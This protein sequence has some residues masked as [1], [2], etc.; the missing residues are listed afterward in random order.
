M[1]D[2]PHIEYLTIRVRG[3]RVVT[4]TI[5]GPPPVQATFEKLCEVLQDIKFQDF[6]DQ[7]FTRVIPK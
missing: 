2:L 1:S 3:P 5:P 6:T 4:V 7:D